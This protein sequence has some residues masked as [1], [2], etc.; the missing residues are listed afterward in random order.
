MQFG[1]GKSRAFHGFLCN[2][3]F[4]TSSTLYF[5][6]IL[7]C[8]HLAEKPAYQKKSPGHLPGR[9]R[10]KLYFY[11][12]GFSIASINSEWKMNLESPHLDEGC[13][14]RKYFK[15]SNC[16]QQRQSNSHRLNWQGGLFFP[17]LLYDFAFQ[18]P[19]IW[20]ES[21]LYCGVIVPLSYPLHSNKTVLAIYKSLPTTTM[22]F[23]NFFCCQ[24]KYIGSIFYCVLLL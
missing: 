12:F 4:A 2:I 1:I 16:S 9:S 6:Q 21:Y 3:K 13:G 23:L 22:H 10:V 7:M 11:G 20:I 18:A 24:G 14:L 5:L 15:I 17:T 8:C 19:L